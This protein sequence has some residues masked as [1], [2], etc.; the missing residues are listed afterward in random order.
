MRKVL[1][2]IID[3]GLIGLDVWLYFKA[4]SDTGVFLLLFGVGSAIAIPVGVGLINYAFGEK[5]RDA[6]K[7][8]T[9]VPEIEQLISNAE[10]QE[11]KIE[12][13]KQEYVKL[14]STI[15]SESERLALT[16]RKEELEKNAKRILGELNIIES[17]IQSLDR[18]TVRNVPTKEV[19]RLRERVEAI[20][21]GDLVIRVGH[22]QFVIEREL[23][24]RTPLFGF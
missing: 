19:Q 2:V 24:M 1:F 3:L 17:E 4:E 21:R 6:F 22:S 20:R 10:T 5:Q 15:Q 18:S 7:K 8:L 23:I 16:T 14:Q 13:L 12:I 11:K 9:K